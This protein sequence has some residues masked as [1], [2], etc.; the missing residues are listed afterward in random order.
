MLK[1]SPFLNAHS[2]KRTN[3]KEAKNQV[4][5][6]A[7]NLEEKLNKNKLSADFGI[8]PLWKIKTNHWIGVGAAILNS[9]KARRLVWR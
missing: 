1:S 7:P 2:M 9:K 8:M 4:V 3:H 5:Y 6:P